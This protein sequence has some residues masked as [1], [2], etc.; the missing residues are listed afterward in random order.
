[1]K[2]KTKLKTYNVFYTHPAHECEL[3]VKAKSLKEAV[4]KVEDVL[5]NSVMSVRG[6]WECK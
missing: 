2:K 1:M 3:I 6:G 5:T 4:K